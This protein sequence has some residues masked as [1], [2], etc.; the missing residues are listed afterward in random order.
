MDITV[1]GAGSRGRTAAERPASSYRWVVL[2]FG[3]LAYGASLFARQNYA[4]IQKFIAA[5]LHLDK[6]ALGLL[7]SV[8]FYS[9][10]LFQMPWGIASDRWGSRGV[11][12]IGVL[13]I[14]AT[15]AGFAVSRNT[16]DL[17]V[18]RTLSGIAGAAVY[19][20]M[21]GGVARWFPAAERGFS[22]TA[23]GGIGGGAGESA[24][25]F[26][27]PAMS[28][29]LASGWRPATLMMAAAFAVLAVLCALFLRSAPSSSAATREKAF[30]SALLADRRLW[31]YTFL[32]SSFI[33]AIR[34]VQPWIPVYAADVYVARGLATNRAVLQGGVLAAVAYSIGGRAIGCPL[35]GRASDAALRA[36]VP[37]TTVAIVWLVLLIAFLAMLS[38]GVTTTLALGATA[39]L[40]GTATN[41]FSLISAA[42]ADTYGP[43]RT[44]SILAFVN[45]VA[46][47][48]GAT[49]LAISGYAGIS[50]SSQVGNALA[51]Y[52]GIWLSAAAGVAVMLTLGVLILRGSPELRQPVR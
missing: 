43:E 51:E 24:A 25:F 22:Q 16:T 47:F 20:A 21:S 9:Y 50:L 28:I 34:I 10:A 6:A 33:V 18:W 3:I 40:L 31:A 30:D 46:Q 41:S 35:G 19:V 42:I 39:F 14:A 37:R 45:M 38:R 52:R 23:L 17:L 1:R 13:L 8:F 27:L 4:G 12:A 15:M 49:A 26:L 29:Y 7:G 48:A 32:F 11:T 36:G 44:A 2:A 5:D